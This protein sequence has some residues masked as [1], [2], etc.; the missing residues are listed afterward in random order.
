MRT[1]W[2]GN[3][4]AILVTR[5]EIVRARQREAV[6]DVL[7]SEDMERSG[8]EW[9]D[10]SLEDLFDDPD[11]RMAELMTA[12]LTAFAVNAESA[13]K[14]EERKGGSPEDIIARFRE[15]FDLT[16]SISVSQSARSSQ[17]RP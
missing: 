10:E 7:V 2:Q 3:E 1:E 11:P 4:F 16:L 5:D 6:L 14:I 12:E 13:L 8:V 17:G 15:H 9:R